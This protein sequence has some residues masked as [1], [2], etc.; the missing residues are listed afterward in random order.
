[1]KTC[2]LAFLL[3]AAFSIAC[4]EALDFR[5]SSHTRDG[6]PQQKREATG[7]ANLVF[8]SA[9]NGQS[10]QDISDGLPEPVQD[11]YGL[12][13]NAFFADGNGLWLTD[14]KGIY[15]SQ[16]NF[17]APFW[18]NASIPAE[19]SNITTGT[20]GIFAF[21]HLAGIFQKTIGTGEWSPVFTEFREQRVRS[22]LETAAGTLFISTDKGLFKSTDSGK[23]WK[24]LPCG[25]LGGKL[26]ES[27]GVL[28]TTGPRG[29]M[30]STDDGENWYWVLQEGGVGID[31]APIDGGF[32]SITFSTAT[33]TR[34]VRTSYDG[35]K[36]WQ[37]IDAGLP[38]QLS[39]ASIIQVGDDFFCGHPKGIFKSSDKGK[40]WQ[41][42]LP[43]VG[44]KVFHL[45]VSGNVIYAIPRIVGC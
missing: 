41:L 27:N 25:G 44:D 38:A 31:V 20:N 23:T 19:H 33:N 36:T 10:W 6:L 28:L 15:H 37:P 1:M 21:H 29:I 40:T 42:I 7:T 39:I 32:A 43:S 4:N 9:D 8:R 11:D 22:V 45:W 34:R 5:T 24:L 12:G 30:R 2:H 35:G 18:T 13:R 17:T 16:P 3:L 26:V 14:G